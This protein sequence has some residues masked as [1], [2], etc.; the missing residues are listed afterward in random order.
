MKYKY[1]Q[2]QKQKLRDCFSDILVIEQALNKQMG[3]GRYF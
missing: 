1:Q 3:N 2:K